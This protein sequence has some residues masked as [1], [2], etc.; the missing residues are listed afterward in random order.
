METAVTPAVPGL[1]VLVHRF[2]WCSC[3]SE[4]FLDDHI[5]LESFMQPVAS[6]RA[7]A[8]SYGIG[9]FDR[10]EHLFGHFDDH[11]DNLVKLEFGNE[12]EV[13]RLMTAL[14]ALT[15][16]H[17]A[18]WLDQLSIPQD[19]ASIRLHL[20]HMPQIY[21]R[22][23]VVVLLPNSPCPCLEEAFQA[24]TTRGSWVWTDGDFNITAVASMCLNAFPVSAYNFRLWT[25]LEF[26]FATAISIH[27][28]GP[29]GGRCSLGNFDW[30]YKTTVIPT[31]SEGYLSHWAKQKYAK[32]SEMSRNQG[33][34]AEEMAWSVFR[35]A[36]IKGR[37]HL[38]DAIAHFYQDQDMDSF[39]ATLDHTYAQL[40]RFILGERLQRSKDE[41]DSIFAPERFRGEHVAS[42]QKDFAV[43]IL[44]S[45][46]AYKLPS[47]YEDEEVT[48]PYLVQDGIEQ[49]E[50][51]NGALLT[52]L[53]KGLFELGKGSMRCK[54]TIHLRVEHIHCVGDVYGS[55]QASLFRPFILPDLTVLRLRGDARSCASR[56]P[57]SMTYLEAFGGEFRTSDVCEFMRKVVS[58]RSGNFGRSRVQAYKAWASAMIR[59]RNIVY[60]TRWPSPEHE[61]AI[62]EEAI[63]YDWPWGPWPEI[64]HERVCY[65]L[66]CSYVCIHPDVARE[67]GLKLLVKTSDPPCIGLFNGVIFNNLAAR[68]QIHGSG[69]SNDPGSLFLRWWRKC[70]EAAAYFC[71]LIGRNPGYTLAPRD[72]PESIERYRHHGGTPAPE[73][74][75]HVGKP[76]IFPS[77]WL[78][79]LANTGPD[80]TAKSAVLTLEA[81]MVDGHFDVSKYP[82]K[83]RLGNTVP[84]YHVV[85]VWFSCLQSDT[86][87]GAEL[88]KD[89]T[90]AYD[91]VLL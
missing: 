14:V 13:K 31:G 12:W 60:P 71:Y 41:R 22:F 4:I 79:I 2:S 59:D 49:Y 43:A 1:E 87:I 3:R 30:L 45:L 29:P 63:R 7:A 24:W 65:D 5:K 47:N 78:T 91:A 66:M 6:G 8:L 89:R 16:E 9:D 27:Y 23:E 52:R 33:D 61:Q 81:L 18:L 69:K 62:F 57:Q 35:D 36:H 20:Q 77:D 34:Y 50:M 51:A 44:P 85:G 37:D 11:T 83:P 64:D 54:P 21:H 70:N 10:E 68:E 55:L 76:R 86:S 38:H 58:I 48:L 40:T 42:E 28:C 72:N 25:K 56:I 75:T 26:A 88:I 17:G 90:E 15:N 39:F 19:K 46:A 32:C 80:L 73:P 74:W 84:T 53:P 67:K 82:G